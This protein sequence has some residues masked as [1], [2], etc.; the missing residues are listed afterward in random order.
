MVGEG[1]L[2]AD[3]LEVDDEEEDEDGGEEGGDVGEVLAGEGFLDGTSLVCTGD[4]EVDERYE[5]PFKLC[6]SAVVVGVGGEALPDNVLAD[7]GGDEE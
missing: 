5:T 6:P 3:A 4:E 1:E 7:V 2:D